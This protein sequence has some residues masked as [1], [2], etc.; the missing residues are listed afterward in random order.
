LGENTTIASLSLGAERRF[1]LRHKE[2]KLTVEV[3]LQH[4]SLLVMKGA[5]QTHWLH[6]V[7]AAARVLRPRINLTFRTIVGQG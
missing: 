1:L 6:S 3:L 7:P 4:G 5:T 2:T